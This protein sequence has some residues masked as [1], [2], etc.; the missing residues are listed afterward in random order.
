MLSETSPAS[1]FGQAI[2]AN[3]RVCTVVGCSAQ[4]EALVALGL[5]LLLV[6]LWIFGMVD[7]V[8]SVHK[9]NRAHGYTQ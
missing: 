7:A 8:S 4:T 1:A 6:S 5:C 3:A 2:G 9:W